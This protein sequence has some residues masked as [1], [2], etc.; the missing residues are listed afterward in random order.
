MT[1]TACVLAGTCGMRTHSSTTYRAK[2]ESVHELEA[3]E[4]LN[5]RLELELVG[6]K[7]ADT[8]GALL[9]RSE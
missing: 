2:G 4:V 9:L 1:C 7:T 5:D 6:P 8:G 3:V